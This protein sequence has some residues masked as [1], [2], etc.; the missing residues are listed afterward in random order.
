MNNQIVELRAES[1]KN[2]EPGCWRAKRRPLYIAICSRFTF[3]QVSVSK[4]KA[5][6]TATWTFGHGKNR[7]VR[8]ESLHVVRVGALTQ[9]ESL[10]MLGLTQ[11]CPLHVLLPMTCAPL[12]L[13][14]A[15]KKTNSV[16]S[17]K[18]VPWASLA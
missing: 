9:P 1:S 3:A 11:S 17:S 14:R 2:Q 8:S 6:A 15:P 16:H 5:E 7:D 18:T 4:L 10:V 12:E 13:G